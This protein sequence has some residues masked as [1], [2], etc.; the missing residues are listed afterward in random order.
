MYSNNKIILQ[1]LSLLKAFDIR[2]VVISS[3]TR[4][5]PLI[6]SL[7]SDE[8]FKLFSVVDERSA[9][10]FALGLIQ[11]YNEPVAICCTSGSAVLNY[12]SAVSEAF[13]QRLP[14]LLI[15]VDRFSQL[16]GQKEDQM[17]K[18][19]DVFHGFIKYH[20]Q[21]PDI[22]SAMDEWY[23]N[24]VINEALIALNHHGK[25]PVQ[26]NFPILEHNKD[27]FS[28]ERLPEARKI[29][30]HLPDM[31][32]T[33]WKKFS[34]GLYGKSVMIVWGQ[35]VTLTKRLSIALNDFCRSFNC[36]VLTDIIANCDHPFA[37]DNAFAV[38]RHMTMKEEKE[39][40]PDIVINIGSNIVFNSEI[41]NYLKRN[42]GRIENWQVGP[43][44]GISDPFRCLT[45]VF[46]MREHTFF[47]QMVRACKS[48]SLNK[49]DNSYFARWKELADLIK[50]PEVEYSQLYAIGE[51]IK[52]LPSDSV[53]HLANSNTIRMGSLFAINSGVKCYCNRGVNGID[54]C[55]S[56]A[57]GFA[58]DFDSLV[59]L[60]IGDLAFFYDMNALWNRHL[61]KKLRI[62]MINNE[63]GSVIHLA[64]N[65]KM[66]ASLPNYASAGHQT[67]AKG[68]VESLGIKY[69]AATNKAEVEK[70]V[71]VM[72]DETLESPILLEVFTSKEDDVFVLKKYFADLNRYT[73]TEKVRRKAE[74]FVVKHFK[75]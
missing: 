15:T 55:M 38:L 25:G 18:Q 52:S 59:F 22:N 56:T 41:K 54:G 43:E 73:L 72:I 4:H 33:A 32:N 5:F 65:E 71:Q 61:S 62:L 28:I 27:T 57:V 48:S 2:K 60:V 34:D 53:L 35:S 30:M 26:I 6:H 12:G 69:L 3:G 50:N 67:S 23:V 29:S 14:L 63:G 21:L 7:E 20:C 1:L 9:S 19:D 75:I 37:I 68:W 70:G 31:E 51:L 17:L 49:M 46:E 45:E 24:R 42:A 66:G 36:I 74:G 13:Y 10:F 58:A 39:F 44:S 16:L 47:E 8:Y 11:Q 40:A 64:F